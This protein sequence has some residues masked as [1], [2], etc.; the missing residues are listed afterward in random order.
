MIQTLEELDSSL[1]KEK[2]ELE[3]L[4]STSMDTIFVDVRS[5]SDFQKLKLKDWVVG[6]ADPRKKLI[7]IVVQEESGRT[8]LEWR[9]VIIHEMVH[10]FYVQKFKTSTP[11]WLNEGLACFIAGQKKGKK[12][13]TIKD[14]ITHFETANEETYTV[15]YNIVA[16]VAGGM[17]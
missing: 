12:Q 15:G 1:V 17:P 2:V 11:A 13:V 6:F 8:L 3:T 7:T 9:K 5:K 10:I 16:N 14:I 4:F